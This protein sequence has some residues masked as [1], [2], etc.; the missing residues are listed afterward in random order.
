MCLL[1][2]VLK[3][4]VIESSEG[5]VLRLEGRL[6]GPWVAEFNKAVAACGNRPLSVDLTDTTYVDAA[7]RRALASARDRGA[8][9]IT[10]GALM[11]ALVAQVPDLPGTK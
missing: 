10:A 5:A 8:R 4:T 2:S 1:C 9:L 6:V 11:A 7:G 3:I